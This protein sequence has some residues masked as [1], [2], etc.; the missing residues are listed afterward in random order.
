[1]PAAEGIAVARSVV[2]LL[3]SSFLLLSKCCPDTM[4]ASDSRALDSARKEA[5]VGSRYSSAD[6]VDKL[7]Y[8]GSSSFADIPFRL[9]IAGLCSLLLGTLHLDMLQ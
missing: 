2:A 8:S 5:L 1:V 4:E 3:P 6:L 9:L 7:A